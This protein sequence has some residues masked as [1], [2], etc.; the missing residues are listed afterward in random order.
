LYNVNEKMGRLS[1]K[2]ITNVDMC[3]IFIIIY[4]KKE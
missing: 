4:E 1:L 2:I 3:T